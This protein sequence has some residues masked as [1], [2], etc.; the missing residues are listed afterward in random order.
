VHRAFPS[1]L[2]WFSDGWRIPVP[3]AEGLLHWADRGRIAAADVTWFSARLRRQ[4]LRTF[5][6]P[7]RLTN[8]AALALPRAYIYC[9]EA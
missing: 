4:P 8:P 3:P 9:A 2:V 5:L 7:V 6:D 1:S